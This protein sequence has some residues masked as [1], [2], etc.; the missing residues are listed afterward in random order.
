MRFEVGQELLSG[1]GRTTAGLSGIPVRHQKRRK[2]TGVWR[3]VRWERPDYR[4]VSDLSYIRTVR[5]PVYR[6]NRPVFR[7]ESDMF[8][9]DDLAWFLAIRLVLISYFRPL[10]HFF[11]WKNPISALLSFS[12]LITSLNNRWSSLS[13]SSSRWVLSSFSLAL[14]LGYFAPSCVLTLCYSPSPKLARDTIDCCW[15]LR[16]WFGHF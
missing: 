10:D 4:W 6:C 8:I 11:C 16:F 14:C 2:S 15:S 13:L 5:W 3:V 1:H 12:F 9:F 7:C